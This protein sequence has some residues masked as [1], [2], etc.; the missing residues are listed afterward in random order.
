MHFYYLYYIKMDK[1]QKIM[2]AF[3]NG[4]SSSLVHLNTK[5]ADKFIDYIVDESVLLKRIRVIKMSQPNVKIGKIGI[6]KKVFYPATRGQELDT[7]KR[8]Q[9]VADSIELNSK[10]IIAEVFIYD[11][12]IEDNIEGAAFKQHLMQMIASQGRNQIEEA[13]LYGR[14]NDGAEDLLQQFDG[15]FY[16]VEKNGGKIVDCASGIF[17]D[18]YMDKQKI[19]K[20]YKS[21]DTKY[22]KGLNGVFMPNDLVIDFSDKYETNLNTVDKK[23]A[24]GKSFIEVPNMSVEEPVVTGSKLT[25]SSNVTKGDT[26]V[27]LSDA[28]SLSAWDNVVLAYGKAKQFATSVVSIATN[29]LTL[30]DAVPF[31]YDSWDSNENFLYKCT[32]DGASMILGNDKNII[33]GMQRKITIEPERYARLRGTLFVI[34]ARMDIQVENPEAMW[35][36]KGL[37]VK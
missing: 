30:A 10:E 19:S 9:A 5:Q 1:G 27:D 36:A 29:T 15:V 22:R 13:I 33:W 4:D 2:K 6:G 20:L 14:K 24:Y 12:E 11:D 31:D 21:I 25:I 8:I 16:R 35:I 37:K 28:S 18:R 34:T 32:L 23:G 26:T 7:S 17:S 3:S